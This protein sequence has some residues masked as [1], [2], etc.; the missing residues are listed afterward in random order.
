MKKWK[1]LTLI[2]AVLLSVILCFAAAAC[3]QDEPEKD[4]GETPSGSW[5]DNMNRDNDFLEDDNRRPGRLPFVDNTPEDTGEPS[6]YRFEAEAARIIGS[7]NNVDH[8]CT[9]SSIEFSPS[10][11]G[12]ISLVNL[13]SARLRFTFT[14]DKAVRS[15]FIFRMASRVSEGKGTSLADYV[16]ITVNDNPVVDLSAS[17]DPDS[18]EPAEGSSETYF[19]MVTVESKISLAEGSNTLNIT[20][21]SVNYLNLDYIEIRTSATIS[22]TTQS[23]ITDPA[24]FVNVTTAPTADA[25]GEIAFDCHAV[26]GSTECGKDVQRARELPVLTDE[27][28]DYT[29]SDKGV[30]YGIEMFGEDIPVYS[31]MTYTLTL[32]GGATLANGET[33]GEFAYRAVPELKYTEPADQTFS[34][35]ED[36]EGNNLGD[37]FMMPERDM[38]IKPVFVPAP[39]ATVT[40]SGATLDGETVINSYVGKKLDLS[41][42]V[43]DEEPAEGTHLRY[44]YDVSDPSVQFE[45]PANITVPSE[46]VTLA[47][48]FDLDVYANKD[49]S[50]DGKLAT[51]PYYGY[52]EMSNVSSQ[53]AG[54][55]VRLISGGEKAENAYWGY[56]G[57]GADREMGA[58]YH[59]QGIGGGE[60]TEFYFTP[61]S[62]YK[63]TSSQKYKITTTI[64]NNGSEPITLKLYQTN[65]SSSPMPEETSSGEVTIAAGESKD[66]SI[67]FTGFSNNNIMTTVQLLTEGLTDLEIGMYQYIEFME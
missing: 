31:T 28:Y 56:V 12:Y 32:E 18:G 58:V 16:N 64:F 15:T 11:S 34:H 54:G 10:F 40:L 52:A 33:S 45:D 39:A 17:F 49:G 65:S 27:I 14:S 66:V 13:G 5:L 53:P 46:S 9:G 62:P 24:S 3:S 20:P 51:F 6:P 4:P 50:T 23:T 47:P 59:W 48:G 22:D 21:T 60:L 67:E 61:L 44:W 42:A 29:E 55:Y 57:T 36:S 38:T 43:F 37:S 19:T 26:S 2:F 41:A 1:A 35:W 30:R 8:F 7:S 25:V 63:V